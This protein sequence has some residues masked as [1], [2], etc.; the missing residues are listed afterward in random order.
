MLRLKTD[1]GRPPS[2]MPYV[3]VIDEADMKESVLL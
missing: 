1:E 2:G 3:G